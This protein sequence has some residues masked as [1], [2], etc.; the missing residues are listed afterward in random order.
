MKEKMQKMNLTPLP[1]P[2]WSNPVQVSL[3]DEVYLKKLSSLW[4]KDV[5]IHLLITGWSMKASYTVAYKK[6]GQNSHY[7]TY[8][9]FI[10]DWQN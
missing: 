6:R 3:N 7:T 8:E 1:M 5:W 9:F 10:A 2:K 4:N